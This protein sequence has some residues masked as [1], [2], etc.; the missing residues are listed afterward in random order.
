MKKQITIEKKYLLS[1]LLFF[2][3]FSLFA[4]TINFDE[5]YFT[6]S[7]DEDGYSWSWDGTG[8]DNIRDYS[9]HTGSGHATSA[10]GYHSKLST[11]TNINIHGV[12]LMVDFANDFSHLNL[13]GF[14]NA[15][16]LKYYQALNPSDY[17]FTYTYVTL[18]WDNVKSFAV[19]YDAIDPDTPI[20]LFY[21]DLDY[22]I[23]T[24]SLDDLNLKNS[25]KIFP[26]PA[27]NFV[28]ISGLTKSEK[29]KV[30]NVLGKEVLNGLIS[31]NEKI[32]IQV[33]KS[34]IYFIKFDNGYTL[35]LIKK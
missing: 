19:D 2:L 3:T 32:E 30:F 16:N 27:L 31:N 21:D 35:K 14:D 34:G 12:W 11:S 26:N 13:K 6:E 4:Q 20:G 18:N 9:P 29:Y 7:W 33:L 10:P 24:L 23:S 8:W 1:T 15:G 28:Q 22:S 5:P 25:I 17:N